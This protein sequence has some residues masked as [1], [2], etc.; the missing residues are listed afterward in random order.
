MNV[1]EAIFT[2][3]ASRAYSPGVVDDA[4]VRLLLRAAVQAPSAM[5]RQP[6]LFSIVQDPVQLMRYSIAQRTC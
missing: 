4:T 3:R 2:R 1:T 6:W 5:N